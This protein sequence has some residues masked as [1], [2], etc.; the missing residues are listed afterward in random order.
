MSSLASVLIRKCVKLLNSGYVYIDIIEF[1]GCKLCVLFPGVLLALFYRA[2]FNYKQLITPGEMLFSKGEVF[3]VFDTLPDGKKD[4]WRAKRINT[5]GEVTD[6]GN[7][8]LV[9]KI[10]SLMASAPSSFSSSLPSIFRLAFSGKRLVGTDNYDIDPGRSVYDLY[11]PVK[12]V[13][14]EYNDIDLDGNDKIV[15]LKT[16]TSGPMK[17]VVSYFFH[18]LLLKKIDERS[19]LK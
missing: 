15:V 16:V 17:N 7:L 14:C 2:L 18:G 6:E 12:S 19:L 10:S 13:H 4:F 11:Q 8:P 3:Y 9:H 5:Y 1:S